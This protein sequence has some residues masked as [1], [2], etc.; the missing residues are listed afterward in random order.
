MLRKGRRIADND[1]YL[2]EDLSE[3]PKDSYVF[4]GNL[5]EGQITEKPFTLFDIGCAAGGTINY[6]KRRFPHALCTGMDISPGMIKHAEETI[7]DSEFFVG[8]ALEPK[9]FEGKE[10]D[11]VCCSG[12]LPCFNEIDLPMKNILSC[13][14][15][16]G[17][18]LIYTLI[19]DDPIDVLLNYR[20]TDGEDA[21]EWETGWNIFSKQTLEKSLNSLDMNLSWSWHSFEMSS[22][23]EKTVDTMRTWTI[24]TEQSPHQ[25]INGAC[26]L[27]NTQMLLVSVE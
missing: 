18:A 15:K 6:L 2:N 20:R 27:V 13:V 25:L 3:K 1:I 21:G 14:R 17:S 19:N 9:N 24:K 16:G 10:F 26:Q 4:L 7:P 12:V 22:S 8:S 5:L 23:L 11:V